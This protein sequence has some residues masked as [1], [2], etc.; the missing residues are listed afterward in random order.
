M[1]ISRRNANR[2]KGFSLMILLLFSVA[3]PFLSMLIAP[4]LFYYLGGGGEVLGGSPVE[5]EDSGQLLS[6]KNG[7]EVPDDLTGTG[8]DLPVELRN[9]KVGHTPDLEES[10]T[11]EVSTSFDVSLANFTTWNITALDTY[12][13]VQDYSTNPSADYKKTDD[14]I[15]LMEFNT[16]NSSY[17]TQVQIYARGNWSQAHVTIWNSTWNGG[18]ARNEP[19]QILQVVEIPPPASY[20]TSGEWLNITIPHLKLVEESTDNMSFY[21]GVNCSDFNFQVLEWFY[22]PEPAAT[23]A[24]NAYFNSSTLQGPLDRDFALNVS[25]SPL[26]YFPRPSQ[27]NLQVNGT[28]VTDVTGPLEFLDD[29]NVTSIEKV[30]GTSSSN[31]TS[32]T[33][34]DADHYNLTRQSVLD[35]YSRLDFFIDFTELGVDPAR[36]SILNLTANVFLNNTWNITLADLSLKNNAGQFIS[37]NT[38]NTTDSSN[39]V[40]VTLGAGQVLQ[41]VNASNILQGKFDVNA[42]TGNYT[43]SID[44]VWIDLTFEEAKGNWSDNNLVS[45]S[46]GSIKYQFSASWPIHFDLNWT[47]NFTKNIVVP[48]TFSANVSESMVFWNVTLNLTSSDYF[49]S[50]TQDHL[51]IISL[52][53]DWNVTH[54]LNGTANYTDTSILLENSIKEL[55]INGVSQHYWKIRCIGDNYVNSSS[56]YRD[57]VPIQEAEITDRIMVSA[58]LRYSS[59]SEAQDNGNLTLYFGL[60]KLYEEFQAAQSGYLNFSSWYLYERIISGGTHAFLIYWNNGTE[61]GFSKS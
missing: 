2:I 28:D 22:V 57:G 60:E 18:Q 45:P 59:I 13:L 16:T 34:D 33:A 14:G 35:N 37:L 21:V 27:V 10:S 9:V 25:L 7:A 4:N 53:T 31:I 56:V 55:T 19:D 11:F 6:V 30:N 29:Q 42:T 52:P 46:G 26:S 61:V 40:N 58:I 51:A 32:I 15:H 20:I 50:Q 44:Y 24:G 49:P 47:I 1:I 3:S 17:L 5:F 48:T 38:F 8:N 36:I 41:Y 12:N 23:G 39:I 54:V 43:L